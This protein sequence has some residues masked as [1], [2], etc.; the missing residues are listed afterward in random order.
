M[1]RNPVTDENREPGR[2][3]TRRLPQ[4]SAFKLALSNHLKGFYM[5]NF[6]RMIL[7]ALIVSAGAAHA[8]FPDIPAGHWAGDAVHE[9][10]DLG[11]VIGFPDGTFRGNEA[12]TRYQ[13]ALVVSRMLAVV[14]AN[15]DAGLESLRGVMQSMAA[16]MAAM[17]ARVGALEAAVGSMSQDLM[18]DLQNQLAATSASADAASAAAAANASAIETINDFLVMLRINEIALKG[19]VAALEAADEALAADIA[20]LRSDLGGRLATLEARPYFEISG[21]IGLAY[22]VGRTTGA[23][24]FDVDR[25][26]GVNATRNM[27]GNSVFSTGAKDLNDDKKIEAGERAQDRADITDAAGEVK[28]T[29]S[30][31][32]KLQNINANIVLDM[33]KLTGV[34]STPASTDVYAFGLRSFK[35]TYTGI[36]SAPV[37]FDFG[38]EVSGSFTNYVGNFDKQ[39]GYVVKVGAPDFL[40]A[41]APTLMGVYY[42]PAEGE[43]VRGVR[44]TL[45][46]DLGGIS[47]SGGFSAVQL[48]SY[49]QATAVVERTVWGVDGNVDLLG[50][51]EVNFEY[52]SSA[53]T[54]GDA[55][56]ILW[57]TGEVTA[58]L[59]IISSITGNFRQTAAIFDGLSTAAAAKRDFPLDQAGFGVAAEL[60]LILAEVTVGYDRY[61][62]RAGDASSTI[63]KVTVD[64]TADLFAGFS[65]TAGFTAAMDAAGFTATVGSGSA[66]VDTQFS[67][68]I[69][70]DGKAAD[71]LISG[72]N[73][74]ASYKGVSKDET[75]DFGK[76]TISVSA[77]MN[78]DVSVINLTPYVGYTIYS[79]G[80]NN[81]ANYTQLTAG[82][83]LMVGLGDL[84]AAPSLMGAVNYRSTSL[85]NASGGTEPFTATELQWSVG[86]KL[87]EFLFDSVLTA[88]L[89]SW[90]GT[91]TVGATNTVGTG[92]G[93]TDISGSRAAHVK[94]VEEAV[95]GWEVVWQYSGL[96]FAYGSYSS[97]RLNV[98]GDNGKAT[99]Q[100]FSIKYE[101]KF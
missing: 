16:D 85:T 39:E 19:R 52:A 94:G 20:A 45:A 92:D 64:A 46:P 5:K 87:D 80:A 67:V 34:T 23:Y 9:I 71:A 54:G 69:K 3:E 99:A 72:L 15:M 57:V 35:T 95:M 82:T 40:A 70:H 43:Y 79:E 66:K 11:I 86:V 38:K 32:L 21:S 56:A 49:D 81:A 17:G 51:L 101:V 22:M 4:G 96:T 31:T 88:R 62:N 37:T 59:P 1:V 63:G 26:F 75:F 83:G 73:L 91:N 84:I 47:L 14:D 90:A 12:F 93:A 58:D 8:S 30:L 28:P 89:G 53:A 74:S 76:T 36:G 60:D 48:V 25:V 27:G 98:A 78:L 55:A 42:T 41:F 100:A 44:G 7:A 65:L 68:G 10:S 18:R 24:D 97:D 13:A 77:D 50:L 6:F 33:V 61:T 2:E 29:F